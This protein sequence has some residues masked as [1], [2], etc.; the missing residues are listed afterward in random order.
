MSVILCRNEQVSRPYYIETLDVHIY[1][2]QEL[3]YAIYHYPLLAMDGFVNADLVDFVRDE[4][5]MGFAA[6]KME[7]WLK[8][9]ENPDELMFLILQESG[10]YTSAEISRLRQLV[11]VLRKLPKAEYE[12]RKADALFECGQYGKAIVG[13]EKILE[14]AQ[15]LKTEEMLVGR[16]WNNLGACYAKLFRYEKAM[17]AYEK[18]YERLKQEGILEKMYDLSVLEPGL[19]TKER[20][21]KLMTQ[22]QRG[23]W[24]QRM[25]EI[26]AK[27][28]SSEKKKEVEELFGRDPI[29]RVDGAR[30]QVEAWKREYRRMV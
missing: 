29:R 9:G 18:A 3:C 5:K 30:S 22:E 2:S 12:K 21:Q 24:D 8:S 23:R 6:L 19:H 11:S 27:A 25:E 26:Q 1:T 14:Y 4:L 17:E 15:L 7:R 20:Y 10:Y 16:I 28:E 13:Y